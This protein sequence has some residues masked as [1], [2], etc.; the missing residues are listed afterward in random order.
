MRQFRIGVD[1]SSVSEH[2]AGI[3]RYA[4]EVIDRLIQS[5]HDWILFSNSNYLPPRWIRSNVIY[6]TAYRSFLGR[7][8]IIW[9]QTALP[10]AASKAS[11]DLFWSP[12]HR[13]PLLFPPTVTTAL[14]IHDLVWRHAPS[15]MRPLGRLLDSTLM[16]PSVRRADCVIT[17]SRNTEVDLVQ[18]MPF[19]RG[20]TF[21]I[22][23]GASKNVE[24]T[25]TDHMLPSGVRSEPYF[26]FVGTLEPR[27]NLR[28]LLIAYA[29]LDGEVQ[30]RVKLV[31]VGGMGWGK[32][33]I[34]EITKAYGISD[35][36]CQLGYVSDPALAALYQKAKFLAMPSLYEGFG[37]PLLE[38]MVRGVPVLTSNCASMP[39]VAGRAGLLIDPLSI[40]SIRDGLQRMIL[41]DATRAELASYARVEASRYSWD[42]TARQTLAVFE[43][44]VEI[45]ESRR[46]KR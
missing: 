17:V 19:V 31:I 32:V 30:N 23:L 21:P 33:N 3:G 27:K 1:I 42:E 10:L 40:V 35:R 26:L 45:S 38:A 16:T 8:R 36:V 22:G 28:R 43:K 7:F 20:K 6:I 15:T 34:D 12:A 24:D 18:E 46:P 14:T 5:D 25:D 11:L 9:S 37:L 2:P 13:L 4:F 29:M 39:E 44:A 41:D